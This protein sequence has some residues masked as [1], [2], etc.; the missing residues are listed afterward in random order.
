M[1]IFNFLF[2]KPTQN[3]ELLSTDLKIHLDLFTNSVWMNDSLRCVDYTP[4]VRKDLYFQIRDMSLFHVTG[5]LSFLI[6][7]DT[8]RSEP[9]MLV[10]TDISH[11]SPQSKAASTSAFQRICAVHSSRPESTEG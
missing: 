4:S 7:Q 11:Q 9:I 6:A 3:L 5:R 8:S 10:V 1:G 2:L